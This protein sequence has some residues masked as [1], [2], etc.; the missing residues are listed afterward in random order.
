MSS[1]PLNW[2]S[3]RPLSACW[4][5]RQLASPGLYRIRRGDREDLD[6]IGQTGLRLRDRLAMLKG[7]YRSEMPYRDPHT[8]GPALWAQRQVGGEDYEASTCPIPGD[9]RWRKAMEA[10]AIA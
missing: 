6:Y 8:V 5:D 4:L 1:R 9:V 10:V 3:W 2:S 7:V